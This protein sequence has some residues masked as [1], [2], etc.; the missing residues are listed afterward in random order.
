[1]IQKC[2]L[3]FLV[4]W[5]CSITSYSQTVKITPNTCFYIQTGT[6]ADLS[7]G[8]LVLES[9]ET[10]DA[11]LIDKG[12][13]TF[14]GDGH[15]VV[16]RYLDNAAWHL[17]ASPV[18]AAQA[19]MFQGDYLQMFN[20]SFSGW[21]DITST[22]YNLNI[23]QGYALWSTA[24]AATTEIFEGITNS[25]DLDFNFTY[26]GAD[27]G[28]NLMGNPYPSQIDWD[29]VI[30]PDHLGGAFWLFD[31]SLGTQGDYRY[32]IKDG[33]TANTTSQY[34]PSGQ[35]FFVR[36]ADAGGTLSFGNNIRC[37]GGQAFLKSGDTE[38]LLILKVS[39]NGYTTQTAIRFLED[40]SPE[41]DR[42][43]DVD[44]LT[45]NSADVPH[46]YSVAG[47]RNLSINSLP[48]FNGNE[49][50][51][52][53]FV[54]D[55]AATYTIHAEGMDSFGEDVDVLLSDLSTGTGTDLRTTPDYSFSYDTGQSMDFIVHFKG[56]NGIAE[57]DNPSNQWVKVYV[58]GGFL[59][60]DFPCWSN[61]PGYQIADI[62]ASDITGR[63]LF[64]AKTS[65]AANTYQIPGNCKICLVRIIS[66]EN[67][68]SVK[69][70]N[71]F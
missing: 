26:S 63:V 51:P 56:M 22:V 37:H 13:I 61:D 62:L 47:G 14:S 48:A 12:G 45:G 38:P 21:T 43:L 66:G 44:L 71:H 52:V 25:G 6:T 29:Q 64:T 31:P 67:T 65:S 42:L 23:M 19:G 15:A 2:W 50:V 41:F 57:T 35:G 17:I 49:T 16:Q 58:A 34:I 9:D 36:A 7:S 53:S 68:T 1:M 40:A 55:V 33:G 24:G 3:L 69:V 59:H 20:E 28:F 30:I 18:M 46:L 8:N 70:I 5:I 4:V 10:G 60:V 54:A 27:K 11:S 39:G 32:Y